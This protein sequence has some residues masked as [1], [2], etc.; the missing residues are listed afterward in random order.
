M[1]F[2][3]PVTT[4]LGLVLGLDLDAGFL[5]GRGLA[6][7]FTGFGFGVF[8]LGVVIVVVAA[9]VVVVL[10]GS[11]VDVV[12][13]DAEE[14]A[15]DFFDHLLGADGHGLGVAPVL[16]DLEDAIDLAGEDRGIADAHDG[17]GIEK[18][19][20]VAALEVADEFLHLGAAQHTHRAAGQ[21]AGRQEVK[22][23]QR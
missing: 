2:I 4:P 16:D 9:V 7:G 10:V 1:G 12:E 6:V 21:F 5:S 20:I 8:A 18:D 17:R 23:G 3:G 14:V 19:V 11:H 13:D 15:A 22:G